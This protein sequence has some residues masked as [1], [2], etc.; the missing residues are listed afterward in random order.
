MTSMKYCLSLLILCI[1]TSL[2]YGQQQKGS[3]VAPPENTKDV[4]YKDSV[5]FK[6][7]F[8]EL[9]PLIKPTPNVRERTETAFERMSRSFKP[10]GIDSAKAYDSVMKH[11]DP[12]MDEKILF[13]AYRAEFSA[14]ELKSLVAFFKTPAG[15]HYL[16]VQ[17]R[18]LAA[19]GQID[20]Y[21]MHTINQVIMPMS[22]P[23]QRPTGAP[24]RGMPPHPG[25][26]Q[27]APMPGA[28]T[29]KA[30]AKE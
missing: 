10:R 12:T 23:M 22:K 4:T 29:T 24:P 3:V 8:K 14:E 17:P 9:Y 21:V 16:E 6:K 15:K 18:L 28:D 20:Q 26:M 5:Q 19:H 30:P 25:T 2:G 27:H 7:E 11:L 13:D 1:A